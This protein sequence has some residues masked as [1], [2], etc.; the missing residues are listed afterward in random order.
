MCTLQFIQVRLTKLCVVLLL[1]PSPSRPCSLI[2]PFS[3]RFSSSSLPS[4]FCP[5]LFLFDYFPPPSS[6][7]SPT[8]HPCL[9]HYAASPPRRQLLFL[10][11]LAQPTDFKYH[12]LC[13]AKKTFALL[14]L[15]IPSFQRGLFTA[16]LWHYISHSSPLC[17]TASKRL[18][19]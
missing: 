3:S 4:L 16:H 17:Y 14:T 9:I 5:P 2:S 11:N 8:N 7:G 1:P 12:I 15:R 18:S 13:I 10:Q 6:I 19:A